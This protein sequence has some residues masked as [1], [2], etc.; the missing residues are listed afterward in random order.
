MEGEE[1]A[2]GTKTARWLGPETRAKPGT[3]LTE[4][5]QLFTKVK[6]KE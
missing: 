6:C 3:Y 1:E 2:A 5:H 4:S